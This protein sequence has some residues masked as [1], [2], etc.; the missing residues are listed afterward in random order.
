MIVD[1]LLSADRP[2]S[3]LVT[4]LLVAIVA[5]LALAPFLLP[6]AKASATAIATSATARTRLRG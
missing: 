2:G 5:V 6:G 3:R 4:V 1:R